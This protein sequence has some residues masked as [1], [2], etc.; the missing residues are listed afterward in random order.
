MIRRVVRVTQCFFVL[1]AAVWAVTASLYLASS[2]LTTLA[3]IAVPAAVWSLPEVRRATRANHRAWLALAAT[4]VGCCAMAVGLSKDREVTR[5]LFIANVA[6]A[7]F[8]W[9]A[10]ARHDLRLPPVTARGWTAW[11][12]GGGALTLSLW[13]AAPLVAIAIAVFRNRA[14]L[15]VPAGAGANFS[16][17]TAALAIVIFGGAAAVLVGQDASGGRPSCQP[18][19]PLPAGSPIVRVAALGGS[20]TYGFLMRER[21]TYISRAVGALDA[22]NGGGRRF[23]AF[24]CGLSGAD[25]QS[26]LLQFDRA[27]AS[28]ARVIVLYPG[29]NGASDDGARLR[30]D[31]EAIVE[32]A[33]DAD[34]GLILVTAPIGTPWLDRA[35]EPNTTIRAIATEQGVPLVDAADAFV[36]KPWLFTV[37]LLHP[38]AFGHALLG[39]LLAPAISATAA[40]ADRLQVEQR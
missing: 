4:Q 33:R 6:L 29:F 10:R 28:D 2:S 14:A 17:R 15:R 27:S 8:H 38:N 1:V 19:G 34:R 26:D 25:S 22:S 12:L 30:Q 3:F 9:I 7:A 40:E 31:L 16:A 39:R 21:D 5:A 11:C 24:A 32:R 23:E 37:D 35:T 18:R 20:A 36:R 13:Q